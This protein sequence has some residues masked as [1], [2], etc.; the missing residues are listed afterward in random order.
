MRINKCFVNVDVEKKLNLE[1]TFMVIK[2]ETE[3]H[4]IKD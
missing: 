2:T 1:I 4:G 3:F